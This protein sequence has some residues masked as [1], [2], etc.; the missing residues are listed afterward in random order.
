MRISFY[1]YCKR[2]GREEVLEQWDYEANGVSPEEVPSSSREAVSWRCGRGHTWTAPPAWRNRCKYTD[3][4][5]C[6]H[7]RVS[8]EY[9]LERIYP[10]LAK[11]WDY[12]KNERTPDQVL[13][14]SGKKFWWKCDRGH[15]WYK[16]PNEQGDFK[17]CCYCRGEL[18][19]EE[20]NLQ[21]LFPGIARE[22]DYEKNDL[23]PEEIHP[24]SG[25]KV[26]WQC[27]FNPTHK[28][29]AFVS[30]RTMHSQGCPV[31]K[32]QGKTSF[33]EQVIYYYMKKIFPDCTNRAVIDCFEVD[34]FI[35]DIQL[36]IEYN[37][38]FH[39]IYD[40]AE[41]DNR[42]AD[43]LQ[44]VGVGVLTVREQTEKRDREAERTKEQKQETKREIVCRVDHSYKYMNEV[45]SSIVR[46]INSHY[47]MNI[48]MDV[49]V[50]R[51]A[52]YIRALL[53]EGKKKNSLASRYPELAEEWH[54]EANWPITPEM[55]EYGAGTDYT[56]QCKKGHVWKM[57]PNK[58]T[59]RG[60]GC[61]FCSRHRVSNENRL[62]VQ[63]PGIAKMWDTKGND[64]LTPDDVSVGSHAMVSWRCEKG[65][66]WRRNVREMVKSG[67]CPYCSGSRLTRENSLAARKPELLEQWDWEKNEDSPWELSCAN[68]G[69]AYWICEK[70]HSWKAKISN[71]S[72]LGRGCPYCSGRRPT[73]GENLEAVYPKVAAEW[74]Y[75]KNDPLTPKDVRPKSNKKVWWICS[76]GHEWEKE[77][78]A[79]TAG[80]RCP[81]CR[82]RYVRGGNSLDKTHPEVAARWHYGK[83]K[84][85]HPKNVSA[86][87]GEKVWWQCT[88]YPHHEWCRRISHE[89]GSKKGCPYCA[90][91]RACRE[92][93]LAARF[94]ALVRE[95]DYRKNGSLQPHDLTCTSRK[96]VF[97]ICE[98]GH[99]WQAD[100]ASRTQKNKTC[101][102]CEKAGRR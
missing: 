25:K 21:A 34:V 83:N 70:G 56:W 65:H 54:K 44:S 85:L 57:S 64:G 81:V 23:K 6:S 90:G 92:N 69:F 26:Y 61:P 67:R 9:N 77:I 10:E 87:S 96:P 93:S 33:P 50:V 16:S 40:R 58:R 95:W 20:Y 35:P 91:F 31:C 62:S 75:E 59:N 74:N 88:K 12:E 41:Y 38:V 37:G 30:N 102:Y 53:V 32:K 82:S 68:N 63:N 42:K 84:M 28:W 66:T 89:V 55:V 11:C 47:G 43:Y 1:D 18:V 80:S 78:Q 49:D 71:R 48:K 45:V 76:A 7:R 13:P 51:D 97:W 5:Y 19:S 52:Q 27:S 8:K 99:S 3:C 86:G 2:H 46:Y 24:F 101:P 36:G 22:W 4:P 100:A 14:G 79:R 15:S 72:V 17:G 29:R 60:Y 73:E 98:K 39:E 94:P